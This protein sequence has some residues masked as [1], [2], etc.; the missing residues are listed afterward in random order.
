MTRLWLHFRE[1]LRFRW[2][3]RRHVAHT[4][5][6]LVADLGSVRVE[7]QMLRAGLDAAHDRLRADLGLPPP[8]PPA[9]VLCDCGH[10]SLGRIVLH[11]R[12][13]CPACY[14]LERQLTDPAYRVTA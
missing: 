11:D 4:V 5:D 14:E 10:E 6:R 3:Y 12:T 2:A 1:W 9:T 8:A 7:M 13:L